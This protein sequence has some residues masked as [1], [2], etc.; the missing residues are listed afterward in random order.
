MSNYVERAEKAKK[1]KENK[2][3]LVEKVVWML[4]NNQQEWE[5]LTYILCKEALMKWTNRGLKQ[6]LNN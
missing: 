6:L 1:R 4:E 3:K 5:Q 2:E